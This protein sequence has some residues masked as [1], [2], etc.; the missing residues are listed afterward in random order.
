MHLLTKWHDVFPSEKVKFKC[1]ISNSSE[2][3]FSWSR[4]GQNIPDP[5]PNVLLQ[6]DGSLL[7]VTMGPPEQFSGSYT[8]KALHKATGDRAIAA[9]SEILMVH[10]EWNGLFVCLSVLR[11]T[12]VLKI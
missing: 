6:E 12:A 7:T 4:D 10:R 3:T 8:C 11:G 9:N 5:G 2:Y 1:S